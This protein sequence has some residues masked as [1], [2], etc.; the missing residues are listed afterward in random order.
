LVVFVTITS[1]VKQGYLMIRYGARAQAMRQMPASELFILRLKLLIIMTKAYL[2]G[3]PLGDYRKEAIVETANYIFYEAL[4][5]AEQMKTSGPE[6][7]TQ[8]AQSMHKNPDNLFL[9]RVQLLAVMANSFAKGKPDG[10]FRKQAM[11]DNI[12]LICEYL[13]EKV[14]LVDAKFLKVA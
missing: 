7:K 4:F 3:N 6:T 12:D 9:Q 13:S 11:A 10:N 8:S 5:Q 2:K 1:G 14:S